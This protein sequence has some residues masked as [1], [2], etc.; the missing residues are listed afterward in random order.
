MKTNSPNGAKRT[1][2]VVVN[3]VPPNFAKLDATF[4]LAR[5]VVL[6]CYGNRIYNP[7]GVSIPIQLIKHEEVHRDQQ[8]TD[9]EGW[10]D[11]YVESV[12]FRHDMELPAHRREWDE[13]CKRHGSTKARQEYLTLVAQRFSSDLYGEMRSFAEA[14]KEILEYRK[15]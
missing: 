3:D 10:W 12:E 4:N 9:I 14:R 13:Y 5:Y 6:F 2:M 1:P 8:S 7:L 15:K 11:K